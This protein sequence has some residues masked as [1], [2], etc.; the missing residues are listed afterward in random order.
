MANVTHASMSGSNL[1][2][3]KGVA[4]ATDDHVL[5]A[6]SGASV[7]KKLTHT[8]LATTGNP[9]GA[10]LFHIVDGTAFSL[11]TGTW[12]THSIGTSTITN[13]ITSAAVATNQVTL[14]AGTYFIEASV[15]GRLV[16]SGVGSVGYVYAQSRWQNIT[17]G[18]T[19]RVSASLSCGGGTN[20][21]SIA[22][23]AVCPMNLDVRGRF[24]IAGTTVF[25]LQ[26]YCTSTLAAADPGISGITP[27]FTEILIWKTA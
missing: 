21:G 20:S 8:N 27:I 16:S 7:W 23:F 10:Q 9:F 25:E 11:T 18:T 4:S 13:E 15:H 1:H 5:T 3:N 14:P 19:T 12:V 22:G 24:T 26:T 2:E 6:A 17:A